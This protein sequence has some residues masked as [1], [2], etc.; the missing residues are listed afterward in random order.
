MEELERLGEIAVPVL[1]LARE[2]EG[3]PE[4]RRR[5]D[6]LLNGAKSSIPAAQS[7]RDVRAL[8]VL[9]LVHNERA[10]LCLDRLAKGN[11]HACLTREA[12]VA[13]RRWESTGT[14]HR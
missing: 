6:E 3:S 8:E 1:K 13:V 4:A 12:R 9:E 5:I 2:K 11:A 7:L 14:K 10:K